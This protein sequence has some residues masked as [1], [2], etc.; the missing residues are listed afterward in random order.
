MLGNAATTIPAIKKGLA[1]HGVAAGGRKMIDE[2][3]LAAQLAIKTGVYITWRSKRNQQDCA[4]V[5]HK[6]RCFCGHNF[7]DHR[8]KDRLPSCLKCKCKCFEY[9]PK[10]PEEVG[11]WWLV[12]RRG[13]NVHSWRAKCR[14]GC[15]H[16]SHDPVTKSCNSCSCGLFTS[17]FLCLGCDGK[18]EEHETTFESKE[19]RRREGRTVGVAFKPF[20][21]HRDIQ[22]SVFNGGGGGGTSNISHSMKSLTMSSSHNDNGGMSPEEMYSSGM[23][24]SDQY[25]Q[26][27]S[28]SSTT[29]N[30]NNNNNNNRSI[31]AQ[32]NAMRAMQQKQP[33]I[34]RP[35]N[36]RA[37]RSVRLMHVSSGGQNTGNVINRWGKTDNPNAHRSSRLGNRNN[38]NDGN[39]MHNNNNN[40]RIQNNKSKQ[41]VIRNK[42]K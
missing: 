21:E 2:E 11:D 19:E 31:V 8:M 14:C 30:N 38:R 26:M 5:G 17:N 10:R 13:F 25:F 20:S 41:R 6:S 37:E 39:N 9:I 1:K 7:S 18:Y 28:S 4:R 42:K 32:R 16:T 34:S 29:D 35:Y 33:P 22:Q 12:R 3:M 40:R 23:I 15:P 36:G 24:N 27:I